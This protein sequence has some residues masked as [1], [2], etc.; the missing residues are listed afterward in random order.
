MFPEDYM[1]G[2]EDFLDQFSKDEEPGVAKSISE[3]AIA[4]AQAIDKSEFLKHNLEITQ[5]ESNKMQHSNPALGTIAE[6]LER[7]KNEPEV[8]QFSINIFKAEGFVM[9]GFQGPVRG[10]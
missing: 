6:R 3:A 1:I 2:K 9:I 4:V 8:I 10:L 7:E 5:P